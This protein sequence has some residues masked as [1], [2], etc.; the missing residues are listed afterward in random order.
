MCIRDR[1]YNDDLVIG[2]TYYI[3]VGF[4]NNVVGDFCMNVFNPEPP[5]N[6]EPCDA[7]AL[8]TQGNCTDGTT[9]YA[10]PEGYF[11]PGDCQGAIDN[12]VWYTPVSYTHLDVYKRQVISMGLAGLGLFD[13]VVSNPPY[14][15]K[16]IAGRDIVHR[17]K[18]EPEVALYPPGHDPDLFYKMISEPVSYTHLDVYKRQ[19]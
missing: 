6:D 8:P 13:I 2:Q 14:I 4:E 12:T 5:P 10:N 9:I 19:I 18:F 1:D 16:E 17:L 15:S 3:A 11:V 7:I